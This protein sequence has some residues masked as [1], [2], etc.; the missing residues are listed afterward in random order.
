[1]GALMLMVT[2]VGL[3]LLVSSLLD[4]D[5]HFG[6]MDMSG[7]ETTFGENAIRWACGIVGAVMLAIGAG[8]CT[9]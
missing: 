6:L 8:G 3:W 1:M 2:V 7:I 4:W 5:F 9:G